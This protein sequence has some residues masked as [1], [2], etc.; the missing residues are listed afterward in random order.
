MKTRFT[1]ALTLAA[2]GL[3][4]STSMASAQLRFW[5][6]EEQPDRLAKQQEMAKAFEEK[7]GTSVEVIPV[8]ESELGTRATAA[9]AAG[10]LPDVIYLTLQY[11]LPWSEA[12][13]LDTEANNEV[14]RDLGP[15]TFAPAALSMADFDGETAAVPSDGWTQ[16]VLYRKDLFDEAGLEAPN[17]YANIQKALEKLHNPPK[18]YG[19]VAAT[20]I[21]DNFM[22]QVLE[23]VLLAN[24][25]TPVAKDGSVGFDKAKLVE[26]LEF[27]KSI[28]K[29]SPPGDLYWKQS[30]EVY[31]A[32]QAAMIIWSPFIL[33]ELAGLR[34]SAPPTIND[35]PTSGELASK[36]GIVTRLTGPSNPDG[37]AWGDIN[38]FGITNDA[39]TDAAE[40]FVKF[41]MDEGYGNTLSIAPEG[42]FP[43]RNGTADE[44]EKFVDLWSTLPVG[45]DRKKPLSELYDPAVIHEIVSGLKTADRWGVAEGQLAKASRIINS[46]I[47]N[48]LVREYIDGER[49]AS[50]TA[51]LI[52]EEIAAVE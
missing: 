49:D 10:D 22:S 20:K 23:H 18:M 13:I 19:F 11:V 9:Y 17:S 31:F 3:L 1:R 29:A 46:Q 52:N 32:G 41:S 16:M 5:T 40:E 21:D 7:T 2:V 4:V 42:K 24:G 37:A 25:A 33:D 30:R 50:A 26:A 44:P 43:V 27:Y 47:I 51:D 45:V 35:D 12:G 8:T 48:T 28:A 38:Y 15:D 39:D 34:D 36:T 6:I 14:I